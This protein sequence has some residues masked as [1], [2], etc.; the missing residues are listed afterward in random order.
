MSLKEVNINCPECGSK[1]DLD[2]IHYH[3][4]ENEIKAEFE[5]EIAKIKSDHEK[6]N[7]A[8]LEREKRIEEQ[9]KVMKE[10]VEQSVKARLK[11]EKKVVRKKLKEELA[12]ENEELIQSMEEEL[13]EKSNKLKEFNKAKG[14]IQKL[15]REK[16]AMEGEI[17]LQFEKEMNATLEEERRKMNKQ[18]N[19]ASEL[20]VI[21]KEK[22]IEQLSK[23][24][25]VLQKKATQ[26]SMQLQGELQE[27]L[28]EKY[29][30]TTF[31]S[32]NITEIKKGANGADCIQE[33][34]NDHQQSCGMIFYESKNT[35]AFS[36][37]WIP[38]FKAD[39][40]AKGAHTGV[41]VTQALP[42]DQNRLCN[43]DG[44]WVCTVEEFKSLSQV[45]RNSLIQIGEA[46]ASQQNKGEK[47]QMLYDFLVGPE[48][49][50]YV[51]GIVE[52]FTTMKSDLEK[53]KRSFA[54]HWKQRELQLEKVI[55]NATNLYGSV[56][57]IAGNAIGGIDQLELSA[58]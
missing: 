17:K 19:E 58:A 22:V 36:N 13:K 27:I 8:L 42:K 9:E 24:I 12:E 30:E 26:G 14:E 38:K 20:K 15:R 47:T 51:E 18:F 28:I 3:K 1:I 35:K 57:G 53:E 33:V 49:K 40:R 16:E 29:L 34:L 2:E 6:Q 5:K 37:K 44:V 43:I 52:G 50:Q 56:R 48:F 45:L 41:L 25:D 10:Q 21:E 4:L 31:P 55:T 46:R 7:K 54:S 32:D 39:M 23:Q 11:E